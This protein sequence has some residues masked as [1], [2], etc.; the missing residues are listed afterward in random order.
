MFPQMRLPILCLVTDLAVVRG[1]E[2]KLVEA[3][4]VAVEGGVNMV[5]IRAP[6]ADADC[7]TSLVDAVVDSVGDRCVTIM[8]PS[9]RTISDV[10]GCDGIQLSEDADLTVSEVR[11]R[12]GKC[13]LV[14]RSV[15]SVQS[16]QKAV[17]E[18]ADFIVLGTIFPTASH[19]DAATHGVRVIRETMLR[20][21]V[22]IVAIGGITVSN[23][24]KV[25]YNGASGIAVV[26][27]VL[28]DDA[29]RSAA[30]RLW[31]KV[32]EAYVPSRS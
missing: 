25:I 31:E 1:G 9:K 15:H 27:A 2:D 19:P 16:A 26:R 28:A 23:A 11:A 12:I 5:Q 4:S 20:V 24:G 17:D 6:D 29:P 8:N 21:D 22:P 7:F 14:G 13:K 10:R 30:S 32:N 3:V 18:G